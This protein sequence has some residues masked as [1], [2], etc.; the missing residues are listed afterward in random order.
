MSYS[1]PATGA[2]DPRIENRGQN[3]MARPVFLVIEVEQPDGLSTRKLLLESAKYNVL[4]AHSGHEGL[5]VAREHPVSAVI[6]HHGMHDLPTEKLV[7]ELK[8]LRPKIPLVLLVPNAGGRR[9]NVDHTLS[10]HEPGALLS[11]LQRLCGKPSDA[12]L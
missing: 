8:T 7:S 6:L 1:I 9:A 5:E 2:Y 4:T 12:E 11:L 10:S 3:L